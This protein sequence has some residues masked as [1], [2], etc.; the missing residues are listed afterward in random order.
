[1]LHQGPKSLEP[2]DVDQK[3]HGESTGGDGHTGH[4]VQDLPQAPGDLVREVGGGSQAEPEA[5]NPGH[6]ASQGHG[7]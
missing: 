5:K 7:P 1:M 4:H 6:Q 3:A 2:Q